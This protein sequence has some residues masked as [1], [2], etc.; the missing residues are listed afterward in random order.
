M[1]QNNQKKH[2]LKSKTI[3][4]SILLLV[5][6]ILSATGLLNDSQVDIIKNV[7]PEVLTGIATSV[8]GLVAAWGRVTAKASLGTKQ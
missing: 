3:W 5:T 7:G 8:L 2:P 1:E 4:A 6:G